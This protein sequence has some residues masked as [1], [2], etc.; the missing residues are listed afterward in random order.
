MERISRDVWLIDAKTERSEPIFK[1]EIQKIKSG[2]KK[3]IIK[4]EVI[5]GYIDTTTFQPE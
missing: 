3:I 2:D 4:K 5:S 1:K